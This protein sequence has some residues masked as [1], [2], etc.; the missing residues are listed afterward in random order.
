MVTIGDNVDTWQLVNVIIIATNHFFV[1]ILPPVTLKCLFWHQ[2][3]NL[4]YNENMKRHKIH[5]CASERPRF[6]FLQITHF[7]FRFPLHSWRTKLLSNVNHV[8][9]NWLWKG[10]T[11]DK[12]V[13]A[14]GFLDSLAA[15]AIS[16]STVYT[17]LKKQDRREKRK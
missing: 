5:S 3:K 8:L 15:D 9:L 10:W 12:V 6:T 14:M 1:W 4:V 16:T 13:L 2:M 17:S 7:L 11:V